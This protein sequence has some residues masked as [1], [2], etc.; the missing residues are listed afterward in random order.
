M[1]ILVIMFTVLFGPQ[2]LAD[3]E[4]ETNN[5]EATADTLAPGVLLSGNLSSDED[6]D[7]F[8]FIA[9]GAE[10]LDVIFAAPTVVDAGS[11]WTF[12][13]QRAADGIIVFQEI[14]SPT[15][16]V[17]IT[18]NI[19]TNQTTAFIVRISSAGGSS[20]T[21]SAVYNLTITPNNFQ[22]V[23][24]E[25]S[26]VWQD[27]MDNTFYSIHE[28]AEGLLLIELGTTTFEWTAFLG[29]RAES[30]AELD[31]IVGTG[32]ATLEIIFTTAST[33]EARYLACQTAQGTQCAVAPGELLYSATKIFSD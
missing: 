27:P 24:G 4:T 16:A 23:L 13:L 8:N 11:Q 7:Y 6:L 9:S 10:S 19:S 32:A 20:P 30:R 25:I 33:F 15:A 1:R 3:I 2:V 22:P 31:L 5:T 29:S 14:L 17:P 21:P 26:G 18:R 28:N 12:I